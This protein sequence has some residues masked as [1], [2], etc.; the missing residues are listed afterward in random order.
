MCFRNTVA[1]YWLELNPHSIAISVMEAFALLPSFRGPSRLRLKKK[2]SH[3]KPQRRKGIRQ[4][5]ERRPYNLPTPD[6]PRWCCESPDD[7]FRR[8]SDRKQSL[9]RPRLRPASGIRQIDS[10]GCDAPGFSGLANGGTEFLLRGEFHGTTSV[11]RSPFHWH[12]HPNGTPSKS[13]NSRARS[14]LENP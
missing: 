14:R 11:L 9:A 10:V 13:D 7:P 8:R 12:V 1:K 6:F 2:E 5:T 3:A 4:G